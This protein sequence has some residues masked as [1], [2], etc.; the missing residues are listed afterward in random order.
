V[1]ESAVIVANIPPISNAGAGQTI[2]LPVNNV[3]LSGRI[4]CRWDYR[5]MP[6]IKL[7]DLLVSPS[8]PAL[9]L[10]PQ[11]PV[12]QGVYKFELKV[13]DDKGLRQRIPFG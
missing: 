12:W 3:N 5:L 7:P 11:L 6:G 10:I 9:L 8:R 1:T 13:T 4:G 2:T